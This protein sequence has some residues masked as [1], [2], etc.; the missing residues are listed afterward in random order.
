MALYNTNRFH[1]NNVLALFDNISKYEIHESSLKIESLFLIY[2]ACKFA[3][4]SH[5]DS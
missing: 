4:I 2:K 5:P 1:S 3:K